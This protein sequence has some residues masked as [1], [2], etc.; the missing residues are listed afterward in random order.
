MYNRQK[1]TKNLINIIFYILILVFTSAYASV[2]EVNM[3]G[4]DNPDMSTLKVK[5]AVQKKHGG[6][7]TSIE[8]KATTK[9]PN[10]H[11]VKIKTAT[12]GLKYIRYA[13]N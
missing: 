3:D 12:G 6:E 2:N 8:K 10:C 9:N 11:V 13:C 7:V 4:P 5:H 1:N